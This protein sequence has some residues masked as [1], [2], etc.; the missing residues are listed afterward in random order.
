M[1]PTATN[2]NKTVGARPSTSIYKPKKWAFEKN[3]S[4][5]GCGVRPF[6]TKGKRKR[7]SVGRKDING[8]FESIYMKGNSKKLQKKNNNTVISK[9]DEYIKRIYLPK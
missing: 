4:V 5:Y 3:V 8:E 2:F 7:K 9:V 1:S 6:T